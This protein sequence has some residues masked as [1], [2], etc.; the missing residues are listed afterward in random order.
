MCHQSIHCMPGFGNTGSVAP[1][2][3]HTHLVALVSSAWLGP[4]QPLAG[5]TASTSR[6]EEPN[7]TQVC[8]LV[9]LGPYTVA[10]ELRS[11]VS[12]FLDVLTG[13]V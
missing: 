12:R 4:S 3:S 10:A 2:V 13:K 11:H 5:T 9:P 8:W 1:F 6:A 7:R